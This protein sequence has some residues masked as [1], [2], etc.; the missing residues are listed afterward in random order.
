MKRFFRFI[1]WL[2]VIALLWCC[3]YLFSHR[4][5]DLSAAPQPSNRHLT[6]L[7]YNTQR[8]GQFQKVPDNDVIRYLCS[9]DADVLCLQE[10]E[11]YKN[12]RYL[13]LDELRQAMEAYPY[14]YYDFKV[15][16]S[17]R[18]YGN[19]VFSKYPLINKH[20]IQYASRGNITS[21]CDVVVGGDTL[22]LM[23]N[24]LE[25]NRIQQNDQ[26]DTLL[27]KLEAAGKIRW[28]Q[29]WTVKKAM[30][31]SPYPLVV[32]GDFNS[33]PIG[34]TYQCLKMGMRDAFL[35]TSRG[36]LG[37]TFHY[38]R[39]G[40]RIDYIL[41]SRALMPYRCIIDDEVTASDHYPVI[42]SIE[43][44]PGSDNR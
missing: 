23:V 38:H 41:C 39:I 34:I 33:L 20:T 21:C 30:W 25:S 6:V 7:T 42:A 1:L 29:A 9:V 22:R 43:W 19:V 18:Q 27:D 36:R 35:E 17:R 12:N 15:Y 5:R 28:H 4:W 32:V 44:A 10:A 11:V 8:M 3:W 2:I 14:T 13:T 16:N 24:H 26:R 37:W 31:Q 40:A